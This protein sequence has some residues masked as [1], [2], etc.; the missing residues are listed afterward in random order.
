[1]SD[2]N[3]K[4]L[5]VYADKIAE[6]R[7]TDTGYLNMKFTIVEGSVDIVGDGVLSN[8]M[9]K[10]ATKTNIEKLAEGMGLRLDECLGML[11]MEMML[12]DDDG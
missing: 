6:H 2:Y 9:L 11:A 3:M 10:A 4:D 1:M 8:E 5:M 7:E 12:E